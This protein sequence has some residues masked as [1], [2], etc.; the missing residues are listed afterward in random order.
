MIPLNKIV[1][2]VLADPSCRKLL[3]DDGITTSNISI[4][5]MQGIIKAISIDA[6]STRKNTPALGE[7]ASIA[8][9]LDEY[10]Y[11]I[12]SLIPSLPDYNPS[13]LLLQKYRVA[14]VAAFAMLTALLKEIRS[15]DLAKWNTHAR[16]LLEETSEAYVKAKSNVK[17]QVTSHK[18]AFE[19][20]GVPEDGID[21]AL[22]TSY[23]L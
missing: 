18:E 3:T 17:L 15:E 14:T 11:L 6:R 23:D 2:S 20:F 10:Q 16:S 21:E 12:C 7:T 19:F 1:S 22:R 9:N 4:Q 8:K 13:K 5:S